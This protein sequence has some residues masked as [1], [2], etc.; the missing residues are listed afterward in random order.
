MDG[1]LFYTYVRFGSQF[2][3]SLIDNG[4]SC[5]ATVNPATVRRHKLPTFAIPPRPVSGL[6][7]DKQQMITEVAYGPMDIGGHQQHCVY[8]YVVPGQSEGLILG[9][10]Q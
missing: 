7:Q 6:F 3:N 1:P 5:Y 4:C 10:R 2:I 9:Q 8:A